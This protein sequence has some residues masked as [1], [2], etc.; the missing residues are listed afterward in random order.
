MQRWMS[1]YEFPSQYRGKGCLTLGGKY[2][3]D[4]VGMAP[5]QGHQDMLDVQLVAVFCIPVLS[6]PVDKIERKTHSMITLF[7]S[8]INYGETNFHF[9]N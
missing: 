3:L 2:W 9:S 6:V 7:S 8:Y 1:V 5:V 4:V